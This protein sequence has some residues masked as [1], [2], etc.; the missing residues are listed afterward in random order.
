M[1]RRLLVIVIAL[2]LVVGVPL[3]RALLSGGNAPE[4][5]IETAQAQTVRSSVLASGYLAHEDEVQLTTE[6]IGRV[7][8]VLVRE[9]SMVTRGQLLLRIDDE[10]H[11][12]AVE[13]NSA[14]V[15]VQELAI[16]RQRVRL[17]NLQAQWERQNRLH[18]QGLIDSD[19]FEAFTNELLLGELELQSSRES[20][21][22]ARAQ[23]EQA[24]DRLRKT[25]VVAPMTGMVTSLDIKAGE[26]AIASTTNVPGSALMTI[27]N[28]DSILTEVN[29]DEADIANVEVGHRAL[30]Y[31]VAWPDRPVE[32]VVESIAVS[33]RVPDGGQGRSF[34]VRIRLEPEDGVRLRPGMSCRAEIFTMALDD[35]LAVPI[36]AIRVEEDRTLGNTTYSVF[37]HRDGRVVRREVE[38]GLSDDAYQQVR[39]GLEAGDEVIVGPDRILRSLADG[40]AVT[41]APSRDG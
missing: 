10:T 29:V 26:T 5:D 21:S 1:T 34:A 8:E 41:V 40:A 15:R 6:E 32:G 25:R 33:A 39:S 12:A 3:G 22:Q 17:E 16:E 18:D 37:V 11:R 19:G 9:G 24:E 20:L 2:A 38:V 31:A 4:V 35:V 23:L 36:Q 7:T 30:V 27:A 13:Q 28:P 14:Q